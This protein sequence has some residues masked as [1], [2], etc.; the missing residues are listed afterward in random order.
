MT[1]T[2]FL[3]NPPLW[4]RLFSVLSTVPGQNMKQHKKFNKN[5]R[6]EDRHKSLIR[7]LFLF[8]QTSLEPRTT[9]LHFRLHF[10]QVVHI[11]IWDQKLLPHDTWTEHGPAFSIFISLGNYAIKFH[12]SGILPTRIFRDWQLTSQL[13][14]HS[15]LLVHSEI[16]KSAFHH[17][18]IL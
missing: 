13:L 4:F 12:F 14:M 2:L 9:L 7:D 3:N 10:D 6:R 15:L 1:K 16:S 17:F 11:F 8:D 18:N 5:T